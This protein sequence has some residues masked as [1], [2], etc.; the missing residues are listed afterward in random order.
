M[1]VI[2]G[3]AITVVRAARLHAGAIFF[4]FK[5]HGTSPLR[6]GLFPHAPLGNGFLWK[7]ALNV[8]LL[9][10]A[11]SRR[12]SFIRHTPVCPFPFGGRFCVGQNRFAVRLYAVRFLRASQDAAFACCE[13]AC[14][15]GLCRKNADQENVGQGTVFVAWSISFFS[16]FTVVHASSKWVQGAFTSRERGFCKYLRI[17]TVL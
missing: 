15:R 7:N 9:Y 12:A 13:S 2:T 10:P 4:E 1:A 6:R 16:R 11:D 8:V 17:L 5:G 14:L 3:D